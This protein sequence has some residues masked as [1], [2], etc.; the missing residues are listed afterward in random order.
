MK[1][2]YLILAMAFVLLLQVPMASAQQKKAVTTQKKTTSTVKK[3]AAGGTKK[4]STGKTQQKGKTTKKGQTTNYTKTD[5]IKS[6]ESQRSKIQKDISIKEKELQAN[7]NDVQKNLQSLVTITS[8]ID[9]HQKSIDTIQHDLKYIDSDIDI[10]KS[11]ILSLE[12]QLGERREKFIQ[13]M[14]YMAR[15]RSIQDKLMFIFGAKSLTQ[16]YRR[17]RFVREYAAFQRAQGERIKAKQM[18][19]ADKNQQLQDVRKHKTVL[20]TRESQEH[21]LLENKKVERSQIVTNLQ[22]QQKELQGVLDTQRKQRA[23]LDAQIDRLIAIEMRKARERAAA[24]AQKRAA[25]EAAAR[26]KRE[27]ELARKRA[28]AEAERKANE[29][30]IREAREREAKAKEEARAAAAAADKAQRERAEQRAREAEEARLAAERKAANDIKRAEREETEAKKAE[31][32]ADRLS[33]VDTRLSGSFANNTGRLPWPMTG[34]VVGRYGQYTV[35]GLQNVTLSNDGINIK[36]AA[37]AAVRSV[38]AGEVSGVFGIGGT[39]VV[40][41]RHGIYMTVYCNLSSVSVSRGQQVKAG[42]TLGTVGS[43]GILQFQLR[44]ETAKLNPQQWLR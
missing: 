31:E 27:E 2:V 29:Q 18:Q 41:V 14:R 38:F 10:I 1:Q 42:Q 9:L 4:K 15:H 25:A 33:S 35:E 3:P 43:D 40:M 11:Q 20:L 12:E 13:S 8:E 21:A 17:L 34:S 32:N 23:A 22:A 30:R 19:L 7:K 28:A 37:G 26:K 16:M 39:T 24:E 6:L 5:E 36:G 44:K